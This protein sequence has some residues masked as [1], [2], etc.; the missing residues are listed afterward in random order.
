MARR[1][2]GC[3]AGFVLRKEHP[4]R[5]DDSGEN[6]SHTVPP[7]QFRYRLTADAALVFAMSI[8]GET[9]LHREHPSLDFLP[10]AAW[11]RSR[12]ALHVFFNW[13]VYP[14]LKGCFLN[15]FFNI[16][17]TNPNPM[18]NVH[19]QHRPFTCLPPRQVSQGVAV[20]E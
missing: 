3:S 1:V 5:D 7:R 19:F 9:N 13:H 17:D 11:I 12:T 15:Q 16:N 4:F 8:R 14:R 10:P 6:D 18:R 2:A 20:A